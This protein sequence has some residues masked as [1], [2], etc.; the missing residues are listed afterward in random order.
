MSNNDT[1]TFQFFQIPQLVKSNKKFAKKNNWIHLT[2]I[3]LSA[4]AE[5][6][7]CCKFCPSSSFDIVPT[8]SVNISR[9]CPVSV[10]VCFKLFKSHSVM[11]ASVFPQI[12]LLSMINEVKMVDLIFDPSR[13]CTSCHMI[14]NLKSSS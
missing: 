14:T 5:I 10:A 3:V 7:I 2:R 4:D 9:V 1:K 8:V 11:V 12:N 6:N 13:R